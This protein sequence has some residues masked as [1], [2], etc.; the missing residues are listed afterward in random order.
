MTIIPASGFSGALLSQ[1]IADVV[2]HALSTH[3]RARVVSPPKILV[4]DNAPGSISSV[5]EAP[6][7]S[8]NASETV[9][10]H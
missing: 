3:I 4:N 7:T 6:Y 10:D 1:E 8:I 9:L 2:L 5:N